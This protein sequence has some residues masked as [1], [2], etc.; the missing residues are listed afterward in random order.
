MSFLSFTNLNCDRYFPKNN[1]DIWP[2]LLICTDITD[3]RC[4]KKNS[5]HISYN[6]NTP[7]KIASVFLGYK[8]HLTVWKACFL[9]NKTV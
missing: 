1:I 6:I 2:V 4:I 7:D 8:I 5:K 3:T 9:K